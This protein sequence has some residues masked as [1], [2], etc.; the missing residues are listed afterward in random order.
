MVKK[1]N[2]TCVIEGKVISLK[3]KGL[4]FP[5]VIN[6]EY[7]INKNSPSSMDYFLAL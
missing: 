3:S 7:E 1:R 6:V 4:E 5:S 2:C